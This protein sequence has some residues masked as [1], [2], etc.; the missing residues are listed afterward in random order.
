VRERMLEAAL[1]A[2]VLH[3]PDGRSLHTLGDLVASLDPLRRE[4]ELARLP[5]P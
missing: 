2:A 4:A 1:R 3:D 5:R